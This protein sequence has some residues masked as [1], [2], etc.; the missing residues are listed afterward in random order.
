VKVSLVATVKDAG[1]AVDRFLVSLAS[2]TRAPDEVVIVDGGST[3]GTLEALRAV[4]ASI[5]VLS[6]PGANIAQGRNRAIAASSHEVLAVTDPDCELAPDWLGRLLEAIE[7]GADVAAGV[8]RPVA[9]S[10]LQLAAASVVPEPEEIGP[11]WMPSSRSLALRRQV[12]DA[13]GGYPEWLEVGEDMYLNHRLADAGARIVVVPGAVVYWTMRPTVRDLWTQYVRYAEG[14][15][16]AGM[17]PRRHALRF[18]AGAFAAIALASRRPALLA[19]A[20]L[21]FGALVAQPLVRAW[22]RHPA[23]FP[24]R[25]ALAVSVPAT[26]GLIETAKAFG[27]VRGLARRRSRPTVARSTTP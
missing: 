4:E 3:D 22:R 16:V 1:P 25:A 20:G 23:G 5:T 7:G 17:H 26:V 2:Q 27:Y 19:A 18:A 21:G 9:G 15:A 11:R 24:G 14:D 8:S 12:F 6:A 10:P 13:A